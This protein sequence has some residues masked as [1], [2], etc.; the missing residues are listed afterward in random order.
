M[1]AP[2][3]SIVMSVYNGEK[4]LREL[5]ESI[6]NQT[7]KSFEFIII[8]DGS[9]DNSLDILKG[10]N[11]SRI[12]IHH[13]ENKGLT[14]SLN[15]AI[16]LSRGKYIARI[17]AD[18]LAYPRRLEKQVN[19]LDSNPEIGIVGSF[20][21]NIDE[22]SQTIQK[23]IFPVFD[24]SI[25]KELIKENVFIHGSVMVKKSVL[26]RVG[27]YDEAFRYAQDYELWGRIA[28][29]SKLHNL[30]ET[31]LIR[32]LTRDSLSN[33]PEIL[34]ERTLLSIKAQVS[35]MKRLHSPFYSYLLLWNLVLHFLLYRF[36][37]VRF[38]LRSR[39]DLLKIFKR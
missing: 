9:T 1:N 31:L 13:Q 23:A 34:R 20:A 25:R 6:L 29:V 19:F 30:P 38:P 21:T 37:I 2:V 27:Y 39:W 33:N 22:I 10:Y 15:R 11:D 35:V 28:E 16:R 24:K 18:E 26:E 12:K 5:V 4:Y 3:V 7:Y 8:N 17:D 36:G 14:K 32:K